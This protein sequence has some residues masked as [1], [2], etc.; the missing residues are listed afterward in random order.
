MNTTPRDRLKEKRMNRTFSARAAVFCL[1]ALAL[2]AAGSTRAQ[3]TAAPPVHGFGLA[4]AVVV[5]VQDPERAGRIQILFPAP[6]RDVT[7]WARVTLPLGGNRT[8]LWAL[9]DVGDEVVIGFEE[10]D[11][12]N[13]IIIGSLWNGTQ[14]PTPSPTPS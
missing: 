13:P 7:A 4:R 10:G 1:A 8:G 5:N 14:P 9:P 12:D 11:P 6:G 3:E 2:V